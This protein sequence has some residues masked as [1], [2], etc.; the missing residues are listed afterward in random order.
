MYRFG[1]SNVARK[2]MGFNS[3]FDMKCYLFS[4]D[5]LHSSSRELVIS[6]SYERK[7]NQITNY[8]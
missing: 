1:N 6:K 2:W 7:S 3:P 4:D 8:P 5:A